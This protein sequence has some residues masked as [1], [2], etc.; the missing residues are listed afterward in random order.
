[1]DSFSKI[2]YLLALNVNTYFYLYRNE[3]TEMKIRYSN[4]MPLQI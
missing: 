1:M 2:N 3:D 4:I